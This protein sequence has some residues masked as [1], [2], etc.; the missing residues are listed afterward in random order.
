MSRHSATLYLDHP[1]TEE[2]LEVSFEFV[3]QRAEPDVGIFSSYVDDWSVEEIDGDS[4]REAC[5]DLERL[6]PRDW[7]ENK[8]L[9]Y[10]QDGEP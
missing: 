6:L 9:E 7:I 4:N 5:L 2:P 8:L 1:T 10:H 3:I